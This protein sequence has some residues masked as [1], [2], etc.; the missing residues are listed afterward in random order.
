MEVSSGAEIHLVAHGG[1]PTGAGGCVLKEAAT[2]GAPR[3]EQ[4]FP[5]LKQ[6][7]CEEGTANIKIYELTARPISL[8]SAPL[9][10]GS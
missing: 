1:S 10:G 6:R 7:K 2:C 5:T 9:G 3:L 8:P 4:V